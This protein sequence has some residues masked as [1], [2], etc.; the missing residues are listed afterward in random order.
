MTTLIGL[1]GW[2]VDEAGEIR[3]PAS[4]PGV[5]G[6]AVIRAARRS[7]NLSE[8]QLADMLA[9]SH[10]TVR[11]WE[12]GSRPL[13][14]VRYDQLR[15]LAEA[16]HQTD[17][18]VGQETSELVLASQCDLLIAGIL[19]GFEDYVEVPPVDEDA[20]G[21]DAR[22]LLRWALTGQPPD[23]YSPY[24]PKVPL[25]AAADVSLFAAI[26]RDLQ[27][28]SHGYHLASYGDAL[29]ILTGSVNG[30]EGSR[31]PRG[32][33]PMMWTPSR[34]TEQGL[35]MARMYQRAADVPCER[36]AVLI[37][38][39][40]GTDK[41]AALAEA[42]IDR[43]RYLTISIDAILEEMAASELIP[44]R[45][46]LSPLDMADLVH[47]ESQFLAKR[48][49]LRALAD[50]KNLIWDI[51]MASAHII[52]SWL[53][54]LRLAGYAATGIF[55][56]ISIE[57]SV[58]RS[59]AEHRRGHDEYRSGHGYGGR[60]VPPEA[61][62]A[63]ANMPSTRKQQHQAAGTAAHDYPITAGSAR[64]SGQ[65]F[66]VGEVTHMIASY[67]ASQQTL[68]GLAREFRARRWPAVP[69]ACPPG[70]EAAAPAIDDPEPYIPGSF[71]DVVLAYDLG[72]IS[73]LEY[74]ALA[75]AAAT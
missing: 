3:L 30:P 74:A 16:L 68:D 59:D 43:S 52:E 10:T 29:V 67:R 49:G 7:A 62:R 66:P 9:V 35:L 13:Y 70:L 50:G 58:R 38:G 63:L 53:G 36:R 20:A 46:G 2:I 37:G 71:D 65:E 28:G 23:R 42:G 54:T 32:S 47:A 31:D 72:R 69:S 26:V 34:N 24:V 1:P 4:P 25:L 39:L 73:D 22:A 5:I 12:D 45:E 40:R 6:A 14:C 8:H 33:K 44:A 61:I 21:R 17:A 55:V 19:R 64:S 48:L 56:D 18:H 51:T 15:R 11:G 60:Y 41:N 57:E 75:S 27:A